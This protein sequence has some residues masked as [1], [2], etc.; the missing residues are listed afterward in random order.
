MPRFLPFFAA[1]SSLAAVVPVMA[2]AQSPAAAATAPALTIG[3]KAPA[4][5]VSE[6]VKGAPVKVGDGKIHVVEF[7]ATWCGPCRVS[8][9]HL[10]ELSKKFAGK[11]DFT[12]VSVWEEDHGSPNAEIPAKVKKFVA[13]MGPKMD[14]HVARDKDGAMAKSWMMA[15]A[16]EGIPT[17]FVVDKDGT[18]AWIGHPM[19][20]LDTTL[21]QIIAG[22]YDRTAAATAL[23]SKQEEQ[24]KE[25][26]QQAKLDE[27]FGPALKLAQQGKFAD[28]VAEMDKT[29]AANPD[30]VGPTAYL[31]YRLM[32][33][34]DEAAAQAFAVKL[35]ASEWKS[36]APVLNAVAWGI[37]GDDSKIK[38]PDYAAAVTLAE[39]AANAS[40]NKNSSILDTLAVAYDKNGDIDKAIATETKAVAMLPADADPAMAKDLKARL[41]TLQAKKK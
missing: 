20:G 3:S 34:Y 15:A 16:Q 37:V 4:I 7:W 27:L 21:S 23:K 39:A 18:V 40:D 5:T 36:N 41:A 31:K 33:Q 9:P 24:A 22:K 19:D 38:K 29:L 11:A 14:Y 30:Y 6:W 2:H 26:A 35:A 25:A 13:T 28:A 17:A 10:T 12:G 32:L 8:I 1:L